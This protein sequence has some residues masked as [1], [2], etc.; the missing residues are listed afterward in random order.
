MSL[1]TG[2]DATLVVNGV[3]LEVKAWTVERTNAVK[4]NATSKSS[5][6][7]KT[8]KGV[9]DWK[10]TFEYMINDGDMKVGHS[11]SAGQNITEGDLITLTQAACVLPAT[12]K[13]S[14]SARVASI[15]TP[16]Q[17]DGDELMVTIQ[18]EGDG[19]YTLA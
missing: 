19:A 7:K 12:K 8:A 11:E 15:S 1:V 14:G 10:L 17:I 9:S 4:K 2:R 13:F 18:A 3:N 5:G 16:V 6:F